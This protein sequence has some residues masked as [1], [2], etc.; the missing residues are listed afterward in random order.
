MTF[1][2]AVQAMLDGEKVKR[3]N[4][5]GVCYGYIV[6]DADGDTVDSNGNQVILSKRDF[7]ADWEIASVPAAGTLLTRYGKSYRL[8]KEADGTYAVLDEETYIEKAK[9]ITE[10]NLVHD[11]WCYDFD[12]V[13]THKIN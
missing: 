6:L 2:E 3:V 13:K 12:I 5:T 11:L 1:N 10:E 7:V 9:G 8:I 4:T